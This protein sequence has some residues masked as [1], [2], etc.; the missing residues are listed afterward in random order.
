[1]ANQHNWIASEDFYLKSDACE[2]KKISILVGQPYKHNGHWQC[3]LR[4]DGLPQP[5]PDIAGDSSLQSLALAI[6]LAV[7]SLIDEIRA[8]SNLHLSE[9]GEGPPLS[10]S[11]VLR[12]YN[13][14]VQ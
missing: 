13:I 5:F 14:N 11:Q 2:T 10:E 12:A 3:P 6:D 4:I 1:M 7:N 9:S 8:G